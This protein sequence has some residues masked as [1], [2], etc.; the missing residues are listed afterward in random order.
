[1]N[2]QKEAIKG[3]VYF[4]VVF[5]IATWLLHD[6]GDSWRKAG[7]ISFVGSCFWLRLG[8]IHRAVDEGRG[9]N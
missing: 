4:V 8:L 5:A 2:S 9:K 3:I 1:M 7:F 6:E